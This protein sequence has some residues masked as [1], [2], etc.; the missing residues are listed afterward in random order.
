MLG[1]K[2]HTSFRYSSMVRHFRSTTALVSM[3]GCAAPVDSQFASVT[4]ARAGYVQLMLGGGIVLA[5]SVSGVPGTPDGVHIVDV[6]LGV[7]A[8]TDRM[9]G[10]TYDGRRRS[11]ATASRS[12]ITPT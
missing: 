11:G 2:H 4:D 6:A 7:T 8:V 12:A 3:A 5:V 9:Q 10:E 1:A